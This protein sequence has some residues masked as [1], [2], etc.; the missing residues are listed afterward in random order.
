MSVTRQRPSGTC[1]DRRRPHGD[2]RRWVRPFFRANRALDATLRLIGSTVHTVAAAR[3][4][5]HRRP[6]RASRKLQNASELLVIASVRL[7]RAVK[8]LAEAT[9]RAAREPETAWNVPE[10]V[11]NATESWMYMTSWLTET[12][13][14][15]CALQRSILEGLEAGTLVPERPADRRPRIALASPP[16]S[17]RAFLRLRQPRVHDRIGPLLLRRRRTPRPAALRVPRRSALG[18]APPLFPVCLH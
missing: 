15:V 8:N 6:V 17:F 3:R 12:S 7:L 9:E 11:A 10:I 13:N 5:V 1:R 14:E 2:Q 16:V 18:R 4:T